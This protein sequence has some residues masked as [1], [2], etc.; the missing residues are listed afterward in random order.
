MR[1]DKSENKSVTIRFDDQARAENL[2]ERFQALA[3]KKGVSFVRLT[4]QAVR[5]YLE[6][7]E[8]GPDVKQMHKRQQQQTGMLESV[9][10]MLGTMTTTLRDAMIEQGVAKNRLNKLERVVDS[11]NGNQANM[12]TQLDTIASNFFTH[13]DEYMKEQGKEGW[14]EQRE[15]AWRRLSEQAESVQPLFED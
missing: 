12:R 3:D 14:E 9:T 13:L 8:G 6:R 15:E 1:T 7:A 11:L 5:E 4:V 10:S 2:A